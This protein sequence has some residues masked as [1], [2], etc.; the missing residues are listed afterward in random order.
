MLAQKCTPLRGSLPWAP[1]LIRHGI[2]EV[3]RFGSNLY[4]YAI[5]GLLWISYLTKCITCSP[6]TF[7]NF[8]VNL[9]TNFVVV[10]ADDV[11]NSL[12]AVCQN[13]IVVNL[14]RI[15]VLVVQHNG[16]TWK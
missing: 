7:C 15:F 12:I 16:G 4:F 1:I 2:T 13:L 10:V 14:M 5:I 6:S 11:E 3:A 8:L 9:D